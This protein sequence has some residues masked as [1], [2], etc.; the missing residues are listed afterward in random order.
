MHLC[1][2]YLHLDILFDEE[3]IITQE[4]S[5]L[6]CEQVPNPNPQFVL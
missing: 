4:E 1:R 6:N 3:V 5:G 2:G